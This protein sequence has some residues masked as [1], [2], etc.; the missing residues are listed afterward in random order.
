M[1]L[2]DYTV[3]AIRTESTIEQVSTNEDRLKS[4]LEIL[5]G[6]GNML[7]DLKKNIFYGREID[8][9]KYMEMY[10]LLVAGF[11][12]L[13]VWEKNPK[14]LLSNMVPV[15]QNERVEHNLTIDP[16]IFHGIVGMATESTELL[17]A[18][19]KQI[20]TG[21]LDAVNT[22]E[23][24]GDSNWYQAI[25][26]DSLGQDWEKMLLV[27]IEKLKKRYADTAFNAE[28]ANNRDLDAERK[29]LEQ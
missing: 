15:D 18:L 27:N 29:I 22:A 13:E 2:K 12:N 26:L 24:C 6:A 14:T 28:N 17:E 4:L 11:E 21:E 25:L 5:I 10:N 16:R 9:R 8:N 19:Y 20:I 1:K 3:A 23:E 7:D